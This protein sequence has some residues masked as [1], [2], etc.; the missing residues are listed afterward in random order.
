M[1][2]EILILEIKNNK[3]QN[4]WN[5]KILKS[6]EWKRERDVELLENILY[7]TKYDLQ[8]FLQP[9]RIAVKYR[10]KTN[11]ENQRKVRKIV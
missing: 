3:Q 11:S 4:Q 5:S 2:E 8:L 9:I 6:R 1:D 10:I 7:I